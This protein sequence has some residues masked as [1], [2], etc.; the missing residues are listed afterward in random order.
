M[1]EIPWSDVNVLVNGEP[2][3]V[4]DVEYAQADTEFDSSGVS[5]MC[6]GTREFE[7]TIS[8]EH[9]EAL[10]R[11]VAQFLRYCATLA[12][13]VPGACDVACR[14]LADRLH[15]QK[16]G[17][18]LLDRHRHRSWRV[19]KRRMERAKR[20]E[21]LLAKRMKGRHDWASRKGENQ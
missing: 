2:V 16:L 13:A 5:G 21:R 15:E 9:A 8:P 14:I 20:E 18:A 6:C 3:Q 19:I 4:T 7:L 10:S 12:S 1:S 11:S 17:H